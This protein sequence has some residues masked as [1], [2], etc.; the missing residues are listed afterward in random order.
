M[1][2]SGQADYEAGRIR[3]LDLINLEGDL[4]RVRN[5]AS[6]PNCVSISPWPPWTMPWPRPL[7]HPAPLMAKPNPPAPAGT[8]RPAARPLARRRRS[9]VAWIIWRFSFSP[10][11]APAAFITF[12]STTAWHPPRLPWSSAARR[13]PASTAPSMSPRSIR[14]SFAPAALVFSPP[15][16]QGG[17]PGQ[18]RRSHRRAGG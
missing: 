8:A 18:G 14:L 13:W 17:R 15:S 12:S 6:P 7:F 11:S 10:P 1:R 4:L 5:C 3:Q 16:N 9:P 2:R